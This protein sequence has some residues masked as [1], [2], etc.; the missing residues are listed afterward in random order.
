MSKKAEDLY[1]DFND[2]DYGPGDYTPIIQSMGEVLVR[3]DDDDYQGDTFVLLASDGKFG[4]L[5]F[6]W[7][8]CSGCDALQACG[9]RKELQDLI[10]SLH[11]S[12]AWFD[13][14]PKAIAHV[15]SRID[16]N[17]YFVHSNSWN[18]FAAK[19]LVLVAA[20]N[21]SQREETEKR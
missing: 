14:L 20:G 10:D 9:T 15:G 3:V 4:F 17:T 16:A 21:D 19:C 11:N 1:P 12:I 13:D 5:N 2:G 18:K 7:G 6:G 8:S